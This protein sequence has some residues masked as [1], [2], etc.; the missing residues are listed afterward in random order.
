MA[1]A[2]LAAKFAPVSL[3]CTASV[4]ADD[5]TTRAEKRNVRGD[6]LTSASES[7][8]SRP[9]LATAPGARTTRS[10]LGSVTHTVGFTPGIG[11]ITPTVTTNPT[12]CPGAATG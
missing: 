10:C 3:A 9:P 2:R 5:E 7:Q 6:P 8:H 11:L 4:V 12:T 1:A